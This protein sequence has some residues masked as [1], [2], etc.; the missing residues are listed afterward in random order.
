MSEISRFVLGIIVFI[1]TL[2]V[3][4][5]FLHLKEKTNEL[6]TRINYAID[7]IENRNDNVTLTRVQ[8][9]REKEI[10]DILKGE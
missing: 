9:I 2:I 5:M 8:D 10:L 4:C 1:L 6:E 7:F 3:C